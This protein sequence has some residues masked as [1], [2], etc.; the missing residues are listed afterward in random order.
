MKTP[1]L[2]PMC[3]ASLPLHMHYFANPNGEDMRIWI[4]N[5][6]SKFKDNPTVKESE[7][8]VLRR[9]FWVSV[10]K[11][12]LRW[13]WYFS[14]LRHPF[15]IPNGEISWSWVANLVHKFHDDPIQR[16]MS[17]RSLCFWDRF[18]GMREKERILGGEEGKT[19]LRE[20]GGIV[21]V[22]TDLTYLFYS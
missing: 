6:I 7:I 10:G 3:D 4:C 12:K 14:Q 11:E 15:V 5:N 2:G 19:K 13:K 17:L 16:L 20:K 18:G 22:K 1:F 21:S 9:Q 8:V